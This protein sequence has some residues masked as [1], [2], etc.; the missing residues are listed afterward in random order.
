[1]QYLEIL[2]NAANPG[3]NSD[4]AKGT[5]PEPNPDATIKAKLIYLHPDDISIFQ[6]VRRGL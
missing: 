2:Q 5:V 4:T 3:R 1:M 6:V